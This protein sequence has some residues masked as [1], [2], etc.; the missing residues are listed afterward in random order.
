[1]W[2]FDKSH[3]PRLRGTFQLI[4]T[5]TRAITGE[6][7]GL[8]EVVGG[9]L[10]HVADPGKLSVEDNRDLMKAADLVTLVRTAVNT[11]FKGDP[12]DAHQPEMPTRFAKML[13]QV[14]RGALSL[15]MTHDRAMEL[16]MRVA[17]D[18]M[19]PMR[20]RCLLAVVNAPGRHDGGLHAGR[21]GVAVNGGSHADPLGAEAGSHRRWRSWRGWR[22]LALGA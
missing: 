6:S 12:I 2:T 10:A 9:V 14:M 4:D 17:H 15:G 16:A 21:A 11:D 7:P 1:M 3:H 5:A 20:L 8:A 19:P 22:W 13:G 18:S